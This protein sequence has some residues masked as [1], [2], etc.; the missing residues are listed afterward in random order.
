MIAYTTGNLLES[1]AEMLVNTVNCVGVMGRGVALAFKHAYPANYEAYRRACKQGEVRPGRMFVFETGLLEN[2]KYIV[3]FPT[4][5][6]WRGKSDLGDIESGLAALLDEV[7]AR[8][9]R[10]I[11][12]PPLGAGLG[13]LPWPD[14]RAQIVAAFVEM[15]EVEVLVYEPSTEATTP[16]SASPPKMTAGRAA[17]IVLMDRYLA[18]LMDPWISLLEIHKLL[19]FMQ[20]AGEPLRLPYERAY[21]GP[22]APNLGHVLKTVEGHYLRGYSAGDDPR[23]QLVLLPG[24]KRE[25]AAF[26]AAQPATKERFDRVAALVTGFESAFGLELLA[27]VDWLV[28]R[29]GIH[30][31][32]EL[33]TAAHAWNPRKRMFTEAQITVAFRTLHEQ[34]W[35]PAIVA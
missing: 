6:H 9:I 15:P 14:V 32:D 23:Q 25:A 11:A 28:R 2:P 35:F 22:Y 16:V 17:L 34:G 5:R 19:Y 10:S 26:L 24:A 18:G 20:E 4:K 3:N 21:Y 30:S 8:E 29:E 27:T 31:I 7:R 12:V 13:G 1:R 33:V